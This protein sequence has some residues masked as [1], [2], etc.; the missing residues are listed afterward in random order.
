MTRADKFEQVFGYR[1]STDE[2]ICNE[3]DWCG[4]NDACNYCFSNTENIGRAKDWW[5]AEYVAVKALQQE[6]CEDAISRQATVE[7]LC[8]L[9]EFMNEK[10]EG[11]G[12]PYV[13]A[14]LFIQDN[15]DEFP[16]VTPQPKAERWIPVSE[17]MPEIHQDVLLSLRSLDVEVGFRG[18]TEP[19]YYCRGEGY[20]D[21]KN[22]LAWQSKPE[23]YKPQEE[24]GEV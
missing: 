10:R 5:N 15:K 2:I 13:M 12:S 17:R 7:R 21:P 24:R 22:V 3:N 20:I 18:E 8:K 14:A 23:P 19:Y 1:P 16:P 4:E 11:L 9:A 6:P